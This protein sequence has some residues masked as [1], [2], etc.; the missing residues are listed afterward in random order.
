MLLLT[1][2]ACLWLDSADLEKRQSLGDADRDGWPAAEDCDDSD[3]KINAAAV[4]ICDGVA[5]DCDEAI[6]DHDPDHDRA[7]ATTWYVDGD[8]DGFGGDSSAVESCAAPPDHVDMG[9][10]CADND[11]TTHPDAV[12]VCDE[13]D[14]DCDGATDDQDADVTDQ[15]SWYEDK[16]GDG[17]GASDH[18]VAC[19]QP[20]ETVSVTGDC[21]DTDATIHPGAHEVCGNGIDEDCD[22]EDAERSQLALETGAVLFLGET[23]GDGAGWALDVSEDLDR[24]GVLDLVIGARG[25]SS[26]STVFAGAVFL[27]SAEIDEHEVALGEAAIAV[28][29]HESG[30]AAGTSVAALGDIDGSG[31]PD[32]LIGSP[33]ASDGRG[34]AYVMRGPFT[35]SIT[36]QLPAMALEGSSPGDEAGSSVAAAGRFFSGIDTLAVG[37]PGEETGG[38]DAGM[39]Y[40]AEP[41]LGGAMDLSEASTRLRGAEGDQAG[42]VI[43]ALGDTDGDGLTELAVGAPGHA[44]TDGQTTGAV[45]VVPGGTV[46]AHP[47]GS[48][49]ITITGETAGDK[50][51]SAVAGGGDVDGDGYRDLVVGAPRAS[52]DGYRSGLAYLVMG[53][54]ESDVDL[55]TAIVRIDGPDTNAV[56]GSAVSIVGDLDG[57]G[58]DDVAIGAPVAGA[59][60]STFVFLAPLEG[61]MSATCATWELAASD[62]GAEAGR[63]LTGVGDLDGNGYP[64]LLIGAPQAMGTTGRDG[65]AVLV[66][67]ADL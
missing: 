56:F 58:R 42:Y 15:P 36:T 11:D 41:Q 26:G 13:K 27:I 45:Y 37:A 30:A 16:D 43:A 53:P 21:D 61:H 25:A 18:V 17:Q 52:A 39:V 6:D 40:L 67:P 66:F 20:G 38:T 34:A 19:T 28:K 65:A 5:N 55:D 9:G 44:D 1:W 48:V 10:D 54:F 12:E 33:G 22:T 47:F 29:G 49:A 62:S 59:G 51:G 63:A 32:L 57:S 64:E 60:G 4:E 23:A 31:Y 35:Q 24:D 14:N 46:G 3:P 8:D 7:T 50:A 2:M